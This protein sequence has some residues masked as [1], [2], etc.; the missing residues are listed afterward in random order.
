MLVYA[1]LGP[2]RR[3]NAN[4]VVDIRKAGGRAEL[5]EMGASDRIYSLP[6]VAD[7]CLPIVEILPI[8]LISIA[9]A[10]LKNYAPGQF[11]RGSKVTEIE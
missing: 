3:L 9:L 2:S 8:Q 6:F 7:A 11:E 5:I 4:L 10:V 1:G